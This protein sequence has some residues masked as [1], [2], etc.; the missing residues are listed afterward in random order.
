[1]PMTREQLL[2]IQSS[3]RVDQARYDEAFEPW[4]FRAPASSLGQSRESYRRD[5]AV[6]AKKQLPM[7]DEYREVQYRR[8][9]DAAFDAME[10]ELL[11]RCKG[12]ASRNDSAP[13]GEIQP[14]Y[15]TDTNGLKITNW[16]GRESF[17]KF[18]SRPGRLARFW[19]DRSKSWYPPQTQR[20]A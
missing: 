19:D 14:Y 8:L 4:G 5:L 9:N 11:K 6:M 10:P 3:L 17:V 7:G 16:R 2:L 15:T 18:M 13:P 1:M 20:S 12:A